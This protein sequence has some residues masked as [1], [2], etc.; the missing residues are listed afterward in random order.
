MFILLGPVHA[1]DA[2]AQH[3]ADTGGFAQGAAG[4]E[5]VGWRGLHKRQPTGPVSLIG[6][7]ASIRRL[8]VAFSSKGK[9]QSLPEKLLLI[10]KW[11]IRARNMG[12]HLLFM[13]I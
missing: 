13:D 7:R 2:G 4:G 3:G 8:R 9:L 10:I 6:R 12:R 11:I 5:Q 1:P